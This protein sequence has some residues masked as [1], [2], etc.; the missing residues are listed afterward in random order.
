MAVVSLL[1]VELSNVSK[2]ICL[3]AIGMLRKQV[4]ETTCVHESRRVSAFCRTLWGFRLFVVTVENIEMLVILVDVDKP[5][6]PQMAQSLV[7]RG[8]REIRF[9]A[10]R[11]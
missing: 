4:L 1:S 7:L 8:I 3:A 10:D 6:I 9:F 11:S 2:P 5:H